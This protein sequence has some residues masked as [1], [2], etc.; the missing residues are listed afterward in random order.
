MAT[1]QASVKADP[2][3]KRGATLLELGLRDQALVEF[4]VVKDNWWHDPL[5]MYQLA[6]Y[7]KENN[8]GRL[9]ILAA[10]R[11]IFFSPVQAPEEAP[12]FIQR[13]YYPIYFG[14]VIFAEAEALEVDPAMLM[15]I[16][17]QESLFEFSALSIAGARGLMQV[18]PA[19]GEYVAQHSGFE[20]FNPDQL[21]LPYVSIKFGSWYINQQ[22]G[23]FDNNQF[24]ALAAYNAG[25][26][27]VVEWLKISDD[28]DVFVESIPFWESRTYI[29]RIYVNLAAYRRLYAA[30]PDAQE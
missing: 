2:A 3:F 21:W 12:L 9:S 22:L 17:R 18:M 23:L 10:A 28:L 15:A 26:G 16:M 1:L 4:E 13:L 24:A 20:G 27:N 5:S 14:E 11:L 30:S 25:P 19:T 29:R 7:F 8:L 6:L